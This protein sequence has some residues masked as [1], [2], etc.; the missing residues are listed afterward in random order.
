[1]KLALIVLA[2]STAAI[3]GFCLWQHLKLWQVQTQLRKSYKQTVATNPIATTLPQSI[4]GVERIIL[5]RMILLSTQVGKKRATLGGNSLPDG[6]TSSLKTT[7]LTTIQHA[8]LTSLLRNERSERLQTLIDQAGFHLS[9]TVEG[10]SLCRLQSLLLGMAMGLLLGIS[11]SGLMAGIGCVL[12]AVFGWN[13]PVWVLKRVRQERGYTME[14]ELGN[15]IEIVILGLRSGLSFDKA[16][17][18]YPHYFSSS[19]AET[20][21][22]AQAQWTHG[23]I[24]RSE[25]LAFIARSYDSSLLQRVTDSMERSLKFGTSLVDVLD[26]EVQESRAIRKAKMEERISKAPVKMLFPVGILI[27]PAM[28]IYIMGPILL[29]LVTG[30]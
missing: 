30:F 20:C 8:F 13:G 27:L 5:E 19:L 24:S 11:L 25:G 3:L 29:D 17:S 4:P 23:L 9:I 22:L 10:V 28:L 16:F 21:A 26:A 2:T 12:G 15:L 1:M 7:R 18:L 6:V 14:Q